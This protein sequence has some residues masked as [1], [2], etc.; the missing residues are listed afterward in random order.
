MVQQRFQHN[1]SGFRVDVVKRLL[2]IV[3]LNTKRRK[4][5]PPVPV[6]INLVSLTV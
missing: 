1:P 5:T 4:G 3:N 2:R 6:D